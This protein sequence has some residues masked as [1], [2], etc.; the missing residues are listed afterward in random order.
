MLTKEEIQRRMRERERKREREIEQDDS[1]KEKMHIAA[2]QL[3]LEIIKQH[4]YSEVVEWHNK[5]PIYFI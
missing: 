3:L 5:L 4:G 2:D 1:C